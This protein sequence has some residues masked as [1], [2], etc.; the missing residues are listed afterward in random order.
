MT[1]DITPSRWLPVEGAYNVRDLGGYRTED[2][3]MTRWRT[4]LRADDLY[5]LTDADQNLLTDYGVRTVIDLRGSDELAQLPNVLAKN[6]NVTYLH[7]NMDGDDPLR[8]DGEPDA[9]I[10]S[11]PERIRLSYSRRLRLRQDAIR[12]ILSALGAK[13]EQPTMFHCGAGTDRTG[14]IAA[15][16]L[17]LAGVA[18]EMIA[19][20][21]ALS[22]DGLFERYRQ[23]GAPAKLAGRLTVDA[24]RLVSAPAEGMKLTLDFLNQTYGGI[25]QYVRHVGVT[26]RQIAGIRTALVE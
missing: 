12:E 18:E 17:G 15:L 14:V 3:R 20:D 7:Q 6:P 1:A 19:E 9:E 16:L 2:G 25:E 4:F 26:D 21:Y 23:E 22:A 11:V 24:V 5:K 13:D 10:L 8:R